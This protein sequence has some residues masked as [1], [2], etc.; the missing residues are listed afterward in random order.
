[1]K[2]YIAG[3]MTG[4][5]EFNFPAFADAA[6]ALRHAGYKAVSPH[7]GVHNRDLTKPWDYYMREDIKLLMNCEG[8]ALLPGWGKSKGAR[9]ENYIAKKL[10][11][12]VAPLKEWISRPTPLLDDYGF[13]F[14]GN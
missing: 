9:L 6:E 14:D 12:Q 5:P 3:P 8:V 13:N 7:E 2:I 11:M 1:M 10:G 4:V